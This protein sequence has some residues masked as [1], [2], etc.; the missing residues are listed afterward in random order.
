MKAIVAGCTRNLGITIIRALA[1]SGYEV[2]GIDDRPM[3]LRLGSRYAVKYEHYE[4]QTEIEEY[5]AVKK[6][7]RLH[8]PSALVVTPRLT[9]LL[10]RHAHDLA[11]YTNLLLPNAESYERIT[12][13]LYLHGLCQELGVP[14]PRPLSE[15]QAKDRLSDKRSGEGQQT[16]VIKPRQDI[17]RGQGVKMIRDAEQIAP[18][19]QEV[20]QTFGSAFISEFVPGPRENNVAVNLLFDQNSQLIDYFAF[21]KLRLYPPDTGVS[22]LARSIFARELVERILPIFETLGWK[23]AADAEFKIDEETREAKLLEING[24]FSGALSFSIACG[25]NFPALVC[26]AATGNGTQSDLTPN[27]REGVRYWNPRLFIKSV[28]A[29]WRSSG[30]RWATV[31]NALAQATGEKVGN[32]WRLDDPAPILGKLLIECKDAISKIQSHR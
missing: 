16:V 18:T 32:P 8:R 11:S 5:E 3:P 30:Y 4:A 19:L 7:V 24:R 17:G 22:A 28:W 31:T 13:K 9:P 21:E 1:S 20:S 10:A 15:L 25:V 26:E 29:D 23:G 27:Y 12:D 6:L 2:I 14:A